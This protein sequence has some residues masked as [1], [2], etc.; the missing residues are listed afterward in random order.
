[1]KVPAETAIAMPNQYLLIIPKASYESRTPSGVV[2][3]KINM[4]KIIVFLSY[5]PA[6]K[7]RAPNYIAAGNL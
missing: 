2:K 1:M 3:A 4:I 6:L 7:K 5:L